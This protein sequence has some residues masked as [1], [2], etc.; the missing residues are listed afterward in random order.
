[1]KDFDET[2]DGGHLGEVTP[3]GQQDM[4]CVYRSLVYLLTTLTRSAHTA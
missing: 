1:M 2:E 4:R 3:R